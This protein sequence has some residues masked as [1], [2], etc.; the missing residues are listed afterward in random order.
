MLERVVPAPRGFSFLLVMA[1]T[2]ILALGWA[3]SGRPP[4]DGRLIG[5]GMIGGY[6]AAL[7]VVGHRAYRWQGERK[8]WLSLGAAMVCAAAIAR[9]L[10]LEG[11]HLAA[12]DLGRM[13]LVLLLTVMAGLLTIRGILA[14]PLHRQPIQSPERTLL[15]LLGGLFMGTSLWLLF[16]MGGTWHDRFQGQSAHHVHLMLLGF[17]VAVTGGVTAYLFLDCP[18]RARGPIGVILVGLMVLTT[19]FG[20]ASIG[21]DAPGHNPAFAV[22]P[23]L[24]LV[25]ALAALKASPAEC[26]VGAPRPG[27]DFP[28]VLPFL[29]FLMLGPVVALALWQEGGPLLWPVASLLAITGILITRQV[30]LLREL[31]T[32]NQGLEARVEERTQALMDL[33]TRQLRH[34]RVNTLAM[35]GAGMIHDLNNAMG[36]VR[37]SVDLAL[38]E[39]D[40]GS[41]ALKGHLDR[42]HRATDQL[43]GLSQR[44]MA[45]AR[46]ET[47]APQRVDLVQEVRRVEPLLRMLV[48]RTVR[49][50][51]QIAAVPP[52]VLASNALVE[53]ALANLVA[54]ARDAMP[55]GGDLR[56]RIGHQAGPPAAATLTISDT[57]PGIPPEV[58]ER[59]FTPFFTTKGPGHGTGLGLASTKALMEEVGGRILLEPSEGSGTT[60]T[61]MF[62]IPTGQPPV[63][64]GG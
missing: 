32:T 63:E 1:A 6:G 56:I 34:E 45:F 41:P 50:T 61:L 5:W 46:R 39:A 15:N 40:H 35:L 25:V 10:D 54:N 36:V 18:R 21:F 11:N 37:A 47:E 33:Q 12:V 19:V 62:P 23:G 53:Q 2:G 3:L 4:E 52:K 64:P 28:E 49:L 30:L 55:A 16:W 38:M 20:I 26:C 29:P 22:L 9:L 14:W 31:K 24:P 48:P 7:L 60:F 42:V 59:V 13:V 27:I 44:I 8:G 58:R 57:G 51:V 43:A 17:L